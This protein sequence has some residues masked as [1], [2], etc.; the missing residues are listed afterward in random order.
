M[1]ARGISHSTQL[2]PSC[3]PQLRG[4]PFHSLRESI[5]L[6]NFPHQLNA[7][8]CRPLAPPASQRASCK[9]FANV[10]LSSTDPRGAAKKPIGHC[11]KCK[12]S[13]A[14]RDAVARVTRAEAAGQDE[15]IRSEID[16][17]TDNVPRTTGVVRSGFF[18]CNGIF[19]RGSQ[20]SSIALKNVSISVFFAWI[21]P[22]TECN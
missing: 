7:R 15:N 6:L 4:R 1:V 10:N 20:Y 21:S 19:L 22:R 13:Q 5:A 9:P 18:C 16:D 3:A 11:K 2:L 14:K 8:C 12:L 17:F